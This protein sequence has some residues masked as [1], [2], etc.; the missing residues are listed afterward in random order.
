MRADS[1]PAQSSGE[2]T[3]RPKRTVGQW[4]AK[5]AWWSVSQMSIQTYVIGNR[6]ERIDRGRL[7]PRAVGQAGQVGKAGLPSVCVPARKQLADHAA[8]YQN[9]K[10]PQCS[11]TPA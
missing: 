8:C 7:C 4:D 11:L 3:K 10:S 1:D 2:P 5:A 6:D 9:A